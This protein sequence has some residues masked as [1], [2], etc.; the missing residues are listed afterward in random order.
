MFKLNGHINRHNCV[1]WDAKNPKI[2]TEKEM[3]APGVMVWAGIW[4]GGITGPVFFEGNVDGSSYMALLSNEF[5]P[6]VSHLVED[7]RL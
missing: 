6:Q 2:V 3:N 5:W 1:Y 4:S 7:R